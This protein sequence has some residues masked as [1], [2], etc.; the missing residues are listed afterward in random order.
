MFVEL[1]LT[2]LKLALQAEELNSMD[3]P[4]T[5]HVLL[6]LEEWRIYA[7]YNLKKRH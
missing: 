3:V 5:L 7:L 4:Q 6:A 2:S 1:E